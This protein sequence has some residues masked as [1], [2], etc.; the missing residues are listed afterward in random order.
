MA[1]PK[2]PKSWLKDPLFATPKKAHAGHTL[3]AWEGTYGGGQARGCTRP[4]CRCMHWCCYQQR[5]ARR[6]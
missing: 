5:K 3:G 1:A 2:V 4:K 6:A